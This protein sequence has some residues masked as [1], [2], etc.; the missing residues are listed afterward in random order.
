[1]VFAVRKHGMFYEGE[2][3]CWCF[4][5]RGHVDLRGGCGF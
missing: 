2:A 3:F 5:F 1:M 4:H